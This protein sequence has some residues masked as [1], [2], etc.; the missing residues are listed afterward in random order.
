MRLALKLLALGLVLLLA[1][2][3]AIFWPLS[4]YFWQG[5]LYEVG[6]G[7][8]VGVVTERWHQQMVVTIDTPS[9]S[10]SGSTVQA[11]RWEGSWKEEGQLGGFSARGEAV[12]FEVA[13][14]RWLFALLDGRPGFN[15]AYAV[16]AEQS[17]FSSH[18]AMDLI[19]AL[20]EEEPVVLP[21]EVWPR[22][23]TFDDVADPKTVRRVD[24]D[25][26]DATFGCDRGLTAAEAP[27][28]AEGRTWA[29]WA[30]EQGYRQEAA[31]AAAEAGITGDAAAALVEF[32][33][34]TR[35]DHDWFEGY[36][37]RRDALK[38]RFTREEAARWTEAWAA[39]SKLRGPRSGPY[40]FQTL[41]P[42]PTERA[43][44][45]GGP[46]YRL[47]DVTL[48]VTDAP[49]TEGKVEAVLGW[50]SEYENLQLDGNRYRSIKS[51]FPFANGLNRLDFKRNIK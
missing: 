30:W 23:V 17:R 32:A 9:G 40:P 49:V 22:L 26:L 6:L 38:T 31:R 28:R 37:A 21:R 3:T 44:P 8:L 12:A 16:S 46:C 25:D 48:A 51:S 50:F 19:K 13:P 43:A 39:Q 18:E 7:I 20:P 1:V 15:L 47:T 34:I 14:G 11:I 4:S 27:W 24:P 33:W 2:P 35:P 36:E 29:S 42:T 41:I 10:V 5:V 45:H